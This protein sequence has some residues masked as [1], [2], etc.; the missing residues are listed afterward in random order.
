MFHFK[1]GKVI[2]SESLSSN[3]ALIS[4]FLLK[5]SQTK[6]FKLNLI[7]YKK[8]LRISGGNEKMSQNRSDII[9]KKNLVEVQIKSENKKKLEDNCT[10]KTFK[11]IKSKSK[12]SNKY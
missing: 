8:S 4:V 2:V 11:R 6:K 10:K 9:N 1:T 7:L 12:H 5:S 3:I